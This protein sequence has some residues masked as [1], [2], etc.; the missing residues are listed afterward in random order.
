MFDIFGTTVSCDGVR[1][2]G[3]RSVGR[4]D[5]AVFPGGVS[6][7]AVESQRGK[8]GLAAKLWGFGLPV[9]STMWVPSCV[10]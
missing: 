4:R 8:H 5:P 7:Q 1:L 2:L 6:L 3:V 9:L 10:P